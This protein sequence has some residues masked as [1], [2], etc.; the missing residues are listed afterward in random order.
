LLP[1]RLPSCLHT[2]AGWKYTPS[3]E[4]NEESQAEESQARLDEESH[5]LSQKIEAYGVKLA[6]VALLA[7]F[8]LQDQA[9]Y[10]QQL[11]IRVTNMIT[12]WKTGKYDGDKRE[13][14]AKELIGAILY[15]QEAAARNLRTDR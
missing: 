10:I 8:D 13:A 12:R 1:P 11:F 2:L 6:Q 5:Q 15:F 4:P 7:P 3:F 9:V 14:L